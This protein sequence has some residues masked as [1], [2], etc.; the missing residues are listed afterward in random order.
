VLVDPQ[1][2][3]TADLFIHEAM[4]RLPGRDF[5]LPSNGKS[6]NP[7]TVIEE[8]PYPNLNGPGHDHLKIQPRWRNGVEIGWMGKECEHFLQ[9]AGQPNFAFEF[10]NAHQAVRVAAAW[11][12]KVKPCLVGFVARVLKVWFPS[13][14]GYDRGMFRTI[15]LFLALATTVFAQNS[16]K[17]Q[18]E[19]WQLEKAYWED[20]KSNDLA[21][22][23]ALW[24]ENFLGWPYVSSTP[25]RK[26]HITDWI[27]ANTSRGIKLQ[28]YSIE[29]LGIQATGDVVIDH[30]RVK[31]TW[32]NKDGAET[33]VNTM[34]I[35]HTWIRTDG[36]WQILGGMSAPVNKDGK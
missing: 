22:Y 10:V 11:V 32:A 30:Y 4:R 9:R 18:A 13:L 14:I 33:K 35:T 5:A 2:V 23:R 19:V 3:G 21:K 12:F 31:F 28:S 36:T 26:D 1:P 27:T 15:S 29:Q 16:A 24:N 17:D 7:K 6:T 34:R 20:V 8:F 25:V